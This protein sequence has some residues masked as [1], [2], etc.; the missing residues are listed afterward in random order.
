MLHMICVT[1]SLNKR[2]CQ[3]VHMDFVTVRT[4]TRFLGQCRYNFESNDQCHAA[5][6]IDGEVVTWINIYRT[7]NVMLL[8]RSVVRWYLHQYLKDYA[9]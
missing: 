1:L 2:N 7:I 8:Q 6:E 9:D 3:A 4:A 5:T